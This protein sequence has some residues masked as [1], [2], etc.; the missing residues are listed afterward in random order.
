MFRLAIFAPAVC[1]GGYGTYVRSVT[2]AASIHA[3]DA[4][5]QHNA[6]ISSVI[7]VV[8]ALLAV[9]WTWRRKRYR[10]LPRGFGLSRLI[11]WPR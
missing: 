9:E 2:P 4:E 10:A 5:G 3:V 11:P 6:I 8:G 7:A 1:V